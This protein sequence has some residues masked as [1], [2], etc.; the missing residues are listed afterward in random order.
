M[1]ETTQLPINIENCGK[2]YSDRN[3]HVDRVVVTFDGFKKEFFVSRTGQRGALVAVDKGKILLVK[4]YRLIING[5]S[6]E[7]PGGKVDDGE[8][9]AYSAVRETM[10]ETGVLCKN[11]KKLLDY[12]YSL[13]IMDNFT[14]IYYSDEIEKVDT[15][16][17]PNCEWIPLSKCIK[18]ITS[19]AIIDSMSIIAIFAYSDRTNK[20][21]RK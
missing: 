18:M 4:Q 20:Q 17:K 12:H 1:E 21:T 9:P 11:P 19:G 16:N 3:Q 14:H 2:V 8:D 13:D 15:K 6:R 10:E 7:I 5:I